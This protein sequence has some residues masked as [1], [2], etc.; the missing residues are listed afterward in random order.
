MGT[1]VDSIIRESYEFV[2]SERKSAIEA[3]SL[4]NTA[5]TTEI[6]RLREQNEILTHLLESEREKTERAKKE[7]VLRVSGLLDDFT[8]ARDR[9]LREGVEDIKDRNAVADTSMMQFNTRHGEVVDE[10]AGRGA[11]LGK[12][13]RRRGGEGKRMRDGAFKVSLLHESVIH[14][15]Y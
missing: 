5:T 15:K 6:T 8:A 10:M 1:L 2:E 3:Q 11:E 14:V 13:L 9:R 7:L 4:A 12:V